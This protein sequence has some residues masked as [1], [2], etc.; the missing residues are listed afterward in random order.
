M[1]QLEAVAALGFRAVAPDLRGFGRSAAPDGHAHYE[2]E[3]VTCD[4]VELL[5]H[6]GRQK[7]VW[8]GHDWG[9]PI[10]WSLA[11]HYPDRCAAV[12]A[13]CVPYLPRGFVP[14]N[15]ISLVDRNL[16]PESEYPAGQWDYQLYLEECFEKSWRTLEADPRATMKALMRGADPSAAGVPFRSAS[17]RRVGGWFGG[18]S[19][20]PDL[21]R[22]GRVLSEEALCAY[23]AAFTA[24]G[25]AK[26]CSWYMNAAANERYARKAPGGGKLTI[27][28][29]FLHAKYDWI[30]RTVSGELA[31]PMR[32]SCTALSEA[33]I[34]AGHWLQQEKPEAVNLHLVAWLAQRAVYER[35]KGK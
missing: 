29:L 10:A 30:C 14:A 27:P 12:A 34:E 32:T 35:P 8:V 15:L 31:D 7:A 24:T 22:D 33:T 4:M 9:A 6:F 2:T 23:T 13:L 18:T 1:H 11:A 19:Q 21:E 20:A 5:D 3:N 25:F 26:P 16:Y 17:L 28:V